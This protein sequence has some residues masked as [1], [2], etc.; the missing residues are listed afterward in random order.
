MEPFVRAWEELFSAA[1]AEFKQLAIKDR[2]SLGSFLGAIYDG[3]GVDDTDM[4]REILDDVSG[5]TGFD[6]S[7][8]LK[9]EPESIDEK[10]QR[11]LE[12][13]DWEKQAGPLGRS[14]AGGQETLMDERLKSLDATIKKLEDPNLS[15]S[16]R[17]IHLGFFDQG[18]VRDHSR[19]ARLENFVL[20][21]SLGGIGPC[22]DNHDHL[23]VRIRLIELRPEDL[24]ER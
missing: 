10:R 9:G 5:R 21:S 20:D 16:Q 24:R 17:E 18:V 23:D 22:P 13:I 8:M 4:D 15:P 19:I 7:Q 14:L 11:L 3:P 6:V 2:G 12:A 1:R